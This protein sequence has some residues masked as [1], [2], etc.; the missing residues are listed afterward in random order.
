MTKAILL[1]TLILLQAHP[2]SCSQ[3]GPTW[4]CLLSSHMATATQQH[5]ATAS[6]HSPAS[7]M[8]CE[9]PTTQPPNHHHNL[10]QLPSICLSLFVFLTSF[11]WSSTHN[12]GH[13]QATAHSPLSTI[14]LLCCLLQEKTFN[15]IEGL[16]FV[17]FEKKL[18]HMYV[19]LFFTFHIYDYL[20][21]YFFVFVN[22]VMFCFVYWFY[23]LCRSGLAKAQQ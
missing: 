20:F 9:H 3:Q 19:C 10:S 1:T 17:L 4:L 7:V 16:L 11:P 5:Q 15:C 6:H 22:V 21:R 2:N 13:K 8:A 14:F 12:R 18:D 23:G